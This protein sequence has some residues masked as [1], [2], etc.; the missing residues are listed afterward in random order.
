VFFST[1]EIEALVVIG[2]DYTFYILSMVP[3][4]GIEKDRAFA[5]SVPDRF[6]DAALVLAASYRAL[7]QRGYLTRAQAWQEQSHEVWQRIAPLLQLRYDRV[8]R[9]RMH[10]GE[11]NKAGPN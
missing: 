9:E 1:P 8:Q 2:G 3:G 6:E 7:R 10:N 5:F 11:D 4:I